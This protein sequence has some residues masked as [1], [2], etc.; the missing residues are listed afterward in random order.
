M[1]EPVDSEAA[2]VAR[3]AALDVERCARH[4]WRI[5]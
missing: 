4:Y 1:T 5:E 2:G 3:L